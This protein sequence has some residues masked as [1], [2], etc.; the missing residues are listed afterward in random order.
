MTK[1]TPGP[2]KLHPG[3]GH[4]YASIRGSESVHTNGRKRN[5]L[6]ISSAS[7]SDLVCEMPNDL[8]LTGPMANANLIAAAP[9]LLEALEDLADAVEWQLDIPRIR[10]A[11]S[12]ARAAIAAAR[13]E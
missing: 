7:Y 11:E 2:W 4:A 9:Q 13:G 8:S 6:G 12:R 10:E 5:S 3:G 1:H